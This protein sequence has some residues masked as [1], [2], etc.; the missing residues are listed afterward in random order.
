M[1]NVKQSGE[2]HR[3]RHSLCQLA[4]TS[5]ISVRVAMASNITAEEDMWNLVRISVYTSM[6]S[7]KRLLRSTNY[8]YHHKQLEQGRFMDE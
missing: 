8:I 3:S 5:V 4:G 2:G 1:I 7:Y 6:A